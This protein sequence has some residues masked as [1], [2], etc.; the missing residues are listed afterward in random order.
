MPGITWL[1]IHKDKQLIMADWQ[2]YILITVV[3]VSI[4]LLI[5]ILIKTKKW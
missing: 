5:L 2:L 3:I 4:I 1:A